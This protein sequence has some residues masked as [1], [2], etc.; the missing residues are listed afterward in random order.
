[1]LVWLSFALAGLRTL[2]VRSLQKHW[3]K[4]TLCT[5]LEASMKLR[6][7]NTNV[8]CFIIK[9]QTFQVR[10]G[11]TTSSIIV[12]LILVLFL[13]ISMASLTSLII[14]TRICSCWA[15][16]SQWKPKAS[17]YLPV[18][19]TDC[20]IELHSNQPKTPLSLGKTILSLTFQAIVS[21][22]LAFQTNNSS[23][24]S[25]AWHIVGVAVAIAFAACFSGIFLR[26]S[27]P[28]AATIIEKTGC[29][30]AAIAFFLMT[31]IFLPSNIS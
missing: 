19:I 28:N 5:H 20:H 29:A 12:F 7:S 4:Q 11:N 27:Y 25:P 15:A 6:V 21:C 26:H 30:S 22:A 16:Q 17:D 9:S 24:I 3:T 8:G 2:S 31:S 23:H 1:M 13:I 14:Q 18:S 10:L